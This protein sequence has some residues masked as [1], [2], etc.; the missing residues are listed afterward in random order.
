MSDRCVCGMSGKDR[1]P[2]PPLAGPRNFRNVHTEALVSEDAISR[3][4]QTQDIKMGVFQSC[5]PHHNDMSDCLCDRVGCHFLFLR[6]GIHVWQHIG[7][8]T[9]VP[10]RHGPDITSYVKATLNQNQSIDQSTKTQ[11]MPRDTVITISPPPF[12]RTD[13][14][15][16]TS[17]PIRC[18]CYKESDAN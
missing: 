14:T 10:S 4:G 12:V 6:H 18:S 3:S 7:Q 8:S 17:A 9:T 1:F 16:G 15:Q 13:N 11:P 5:V 2:H